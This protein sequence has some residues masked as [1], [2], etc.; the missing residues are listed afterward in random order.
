M[1]VS[2]KF[3]EFLSCLVT[4]LSDVSLYS[5]EHPSVRE[6]SEKALT[7]LNNLFIEDT[8][9]L[10]LLGKNLIFNDTPITEKG[11]HIEEFR[12]KLRR[13][14]IEKI[15][16][17]K[18][19]STEELQKFISEMALKDETP[20]CS[21]HI[22]VGTVQVRFKSPEAESSTIMNE[23]IAMIK[24]AYQGLSRFKR[25]D[26]FGL[27][28]AIVGFVSALKKESNVLR[29]LSPV[30]SYS[31]YTYVHAANVSTLTLFQAEFLGLKGENLYDAGLAGLLHDVGKI[32]ISKE[33]LEK[34]SMLDELEW[35]KMKRHPVHGALYL[36][37]LQDVHKLSVITAF[38]HH[39]KFDG[40]GY[41]D[42]KRR[43]R[44][45]HIISQMVAISDFF[46]AM[47]TERPYRRALEVQ[48][49]VGLLKETEERSSIPCL[50]IIFLTH[51]RGSGF[52]II[53]RRFPKCR[54]KSI[55]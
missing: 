55:F 29:I 46:D 37:T 16:I 15:I 41:P 26:M 19:V 23:N 13:K 7:I 6:T 54:K 12:K 36:S 35:N 47:R 3:S 45:Q 20:S 31:E 49:I 10:T 52:F 18:G 9:S 14:G 51:L 44:R 21:E 33:V 40:S 53:E 8:F 1:K 22:F 2:D 39:M 25:L 4:A 48:A 30:K 28:D 38:E 34:K 43:G 17:K 42:T 11:I 32:F 50:L 27:E 5:K 24:D